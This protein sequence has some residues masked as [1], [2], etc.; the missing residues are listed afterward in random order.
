M[1]PAFSLATTLGVMVAVA[2]VLTPLA[3]AATTALM[4]V[5]A[6]VFSR[7]AA[8]FPDAGSSYAW[9]RRAFGEG[10]GAYTAWILIVANFFAVLAT[11]VPAGVYTLTLIAPAYAGTTAWEAAVGC[12]WIVA[13]AL[14][15][16]LGVRPTALVAAAL[17]L[18]ELAVLA[19]SAVASGGGAA[20]PVSAGGTPVAPGA[21]AFLA[22]MVLGIWMIDGWEVSAATSEET[23][24]APLA[25]GRGG[26]T[27][28]LVTAAFLLICTLAYLHF[29]GPAELGSHEIDVL[30]FIGERLGGAWK[31][32]FVA[33]VLVS[34]AA[35]LQTTL[36]YLVR[37]IYAM[38]RDGVLPRGL[39]RLGAATRD[40]DVALVAVML[41]VLLATL[42]V[43][44]V[45]AANAAL[46]IVIGGSAFFLGVLFLTSCAAAVRLLD[47]EGPFLAALAGLALAVILVAALLGATFATRSWIVIGLAVG[48]PIAL[49]RA[50]SN[51]ARTQVRN[52]AA[53]NIGG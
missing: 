9:A 29:A 52:P 16:Y 17:L 39:G 38:G 5:V 43:G 1:G 14:V 18:A 4:L 42:L 21:T 11:A 37:S 31:I 8:R 53:R 47:K 34:L 48:I 7:L 28:L 33:T 13:C 15:L 19:A 50:A 44:L 46:E 2:G 20:A 45:P 23:R 36:L 3:L 35:A 27:G 26:V 40:P 25:A 6:L 49:V 32:V 51:R 12:V 41:A 10:V 24:D 30:A 22:T